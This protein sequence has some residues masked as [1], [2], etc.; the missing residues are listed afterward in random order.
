MTLMT[1][2]LPNGSYGMVRESRRCELSCHHQLEG[3]DQ[4]DHA[5]APEQYRSEPALVAVLGLVA[6]GEFFG[7][8]G[9]LGRGGGGVGDPVRNRRW[10]RQGCIGI[11]ACQLSGI[12][13]HPGGK[14]VS[15]GYCLAR[16][17]DWGDRDGALERGALERGALERMTA[18]RAADDCL[19]MTVGQGKWLLAMGTGNLR[20][21]T[22]ITPGT[23]CGKADLLS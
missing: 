22:I 6:A 14:I 12:N 18:R 7:D 1:E 3:D 2:S 17:H 19:R 8:R 9:G 20:H 10:D 4:D 15:F 11:A 23:Q 21:D 5:N 16:R 13:V